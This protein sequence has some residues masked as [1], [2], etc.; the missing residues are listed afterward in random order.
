MYSCRLPA[1]T[2]VGTITSLSSGDTIS[3][4][5][6][7]NIDTTTMLT[8]DNNY[9]RKQQTKKLA[10]DHKNVVHDLIELQVED[11]NVRDL[12]V[13]DLPVIAHNPVDDQLKDIHKQTT[14]LI[15]KFISQSGSVILCMF[16][17]NVDLATVESLSLAREVDPS[18]IPMIGVITKSD[19]ASNHDILVQQLLM[20]KCD[21][22]KLT[23]GFVAVHN[24]S[25][26]EKMT[27]E[28]ASKH[29]KDFFHQHPASTIAGWHCLG[30][31]AAINRLAGCMF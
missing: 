9:K 3:N 15:R 30:I 19:L 22:Q 24:R 6:D 21:E 2:N 10:G 26:Y 27:L 14:N 28:D 17:G 5:I 23:L 1:N 25:T 18:G 11:P 4:V 12:T 16:P 31:N 13:V 7:S 29:E 8:D 20:E